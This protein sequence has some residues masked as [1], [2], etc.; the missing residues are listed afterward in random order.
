M[1][2]ECR[3][4]FPHHR[5][6][7]KPLVIDPG[8]H[9]GT[10]LTHVPWWMS[11]S[12][13][14]GGE[15]NVP[16]IPRT[17]TTHNFTYL[18]RGPWSLSSS[19]V[20]C[21]SHWLSL[22]FNWIFSGVRTRISDYI[23]REIMDLI[24]YP[25]CNLYEGSIPSCLSDTHCSDAMC[26]NASNFS[27]QI[28]IAPLRGIPPWWPLLVVYYTGTPSWNQVCATDLQRRFSD[29]SLKIGHKNTCSP[30]LMATRSTLP[31]G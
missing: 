28:I 18:A 9:H 8:M 11:W 12:L 3:E 5:L 4:R 31:V 21:W 23:P 27:G 6:Q 22:Q 26:D 1:H 25:C 13:T 7:R 29:L 17:G 14:C 16:G 30:V 19:S 10:C 15:E 20:L 24:T 2:R